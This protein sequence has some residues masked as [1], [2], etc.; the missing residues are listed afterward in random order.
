MDW[1]VDWSIDWLTDHHNYLLNE[2]AHAVVD[3]DWRAHKVGRDVE[4]AVV[5]QHCDEVTSSVVVKV[6]EELRTV[7]NQ[8]YIIDNIHI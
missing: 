5:S 4:S 8:I 3:G 6:R 7:N 1:L 2:W